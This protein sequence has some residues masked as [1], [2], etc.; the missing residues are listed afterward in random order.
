MNPTVKVSKFDAAI[1]QLDTAIKLFFNESDVV[2]IHTLTCAA[3][4]ILRN[5]CKAKDIDSLKDEILKMVKPE[6]KDEVRQRLNEAENFFK[7]SGKDPDVFLEFKTELTEYLLWDDIKL[8]AQLSGEQTDNMKIFST[9]FFVEHDDLLLDP[10]HRD[11]AKNIKLDY[12][13][14]T[15]FFTEMSAAMQRRD[16]V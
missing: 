14:R 6:K 11:L 12:T 8:Y 4:E 5:L 3:H 10:E 7:H 13:S 16:I 15:E 1:R 2:S 9:W